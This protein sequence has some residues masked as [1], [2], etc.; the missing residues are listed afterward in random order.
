MQPSKIIVSYG[1]D[2]TETVDLKH[3]GKTKHWVENLSTIHKVLDRIRKE[4]YTIISTNSFGGQ[5]V[6][7]HTYIFLRD[8]L[9]DTDT[10]K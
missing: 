2:K 4:G 7:G 6:W 1:D 3:V 8:D 5:A 10:R 9:I